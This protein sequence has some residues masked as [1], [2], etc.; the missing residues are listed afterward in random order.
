MPNKL[1]D[2]HFYQVFA[3]IS[4]DRKSDYY[5]SFQFTLK[6]E[7]A[8]NGAVDDANAWVYSFCDSKSLIDLPDTGNFQEAMQTYNQ[9]SFSPAYELNREDT[10]A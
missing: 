8:K 9:C 6:Y 1:L 3:E 2:N 10:Y 7:A 5:E 4:T